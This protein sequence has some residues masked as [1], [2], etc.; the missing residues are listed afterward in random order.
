MKFVIDSHIPY[1]RG[2]FESSGHTCLYLPPCD[3]TR[4]VCSD[5]DCLV[6][7]TRTLCNDALLEGSRV[8]CIATATIGYDHIDT[9]WC[10]QHGIT[11]FSAPG[12]NAK[13][14]GQY[15]DGALD[16]WSAMRHADLASLTIG[17]VGVGHVGTVVVQNALKRGMRVI[18]SD[19]PRS[20]AE[21][22]TDFV[23]LEHIAAHADIV[24]LHTPLTA[25]GP[26]ATRNLVSDRFLDVFS[27]SGK[28]LI[29]AARGGILDEESAMRHTSIDYIIDC[30]ENEPA[31]N[32][33]F[34]AQTIIGTPHI[35]GY[36]AEGKANATTMI[37]RQIS[38]LF[39][40]ATDSWT[41][42][43][44]GPQVPAKYDIKAD[45]DLLRNDYANFEQLRS[46]YR[47]RE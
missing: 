25:C 3:I 7:R 19:P 22:L 13:A 36:S 45:D 43:Y 20:A 38:K 24:T 29:N 34:L 5:A 41:A 30:W 37:V 44:N 11:V 4:A 40:L 2:V 46:K 26:Y 10:R 27:R 35:A 17:V 47:L 8:S 14:V 16:Y 32:P 15:V 9:D 28:L 33:S 6:I 21:N 39:R 42:P 18:C 23:S 1:I 12:C 31:I